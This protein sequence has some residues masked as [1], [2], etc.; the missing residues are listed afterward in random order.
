VIENDKKQRIETSQTQKLTKQTKLYIDEYFAY[1]RDTFSRPLAEY[2]TKYVGSSAQYYTDLAEGLADGVLECARKGNL[3]IAV[4]YGLI[5]EAGGVMVDISGEDLG[6]KKYLAFAQ[7]EH[8]G[9]ISAATEQLAQML[10]RHCAE[11]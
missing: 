6:D 10:V 9:V 1:N 5:K 7:D 11:K 4:A 2:N 8:R 3:E